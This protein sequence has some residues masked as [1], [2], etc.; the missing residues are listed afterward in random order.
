MPE[1]TRREVY[2]HTMICWLIVQVH[3]IYSGRTMQLIW[4]LEDPSVRYTLRTPHASFTLPPT[5]GGFARSYVP[6]L[7][8]RN[9]SCRK[10]SRRRLLR[11]KGYWGLRCS[12]SDWVHSKGR[13]AAVETQDLAWSDQWSTK[14]WAPWLAQSWGVEA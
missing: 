1:V 5:L 6:A 4:R 9:P 10:M 12:L 7:G 2:G 8:V 11:R 3:L 13:S 14:R